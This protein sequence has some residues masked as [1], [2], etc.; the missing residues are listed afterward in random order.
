MEASP[1]VFF[2]VCGGPGDQDEYYALR[3]DETVLL[4]NALGK[5]IVDA[6][7]G[8][9]LSPKRIASFYSTEEDG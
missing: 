7:K 4:Y 8:T 9:N 5:A 1:H 3:L 6:C 2:N